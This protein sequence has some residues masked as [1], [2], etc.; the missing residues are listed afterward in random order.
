MRSERAARGSGFVL[1][2]ALAGCGGSTTAEVSGTITV[3]NK[4][5]AK[6]YINFSPVDG[7]TQTA[8]GEITDGKYSVQVP[9]AVMKVE[10]RSPKVVGKKKDYDSP[11]GK[12]YDVSEEALPARYNDQSELTL[13]VKSGKNEKDW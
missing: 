2:V 5:L 1:L 12:W 7:K 4:P 10:I 9:V 11:K 3:D 8:G 13:D 6:G